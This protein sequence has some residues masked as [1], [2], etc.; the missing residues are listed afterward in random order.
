MRRDSWGLDLA[1]PVARGY[2]GATS[3]STVRSCE[4]LH[5]VGRRPGTRA[6]Q[7]RRAARRRSAL[8]CQKSCCTPSTNVTG[9][10]SE[11]CARSAAESLI[12]RSSQL[13]FSSAAT[14]AMTVRASSQRWQPGRDSSVTLGAGL[15]CTRAPRCRA[16]QMS[17]RS[18]AGSQDARS[19][20]C[21]NQARR[22]AQRPT[23]TARP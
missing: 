4:R 3:A 2:L 9:I 22:T 10:M 16:V 7:A 6:G 21:R 18:R 5:K 23:G 1:A 20:P 11:Y 8:T 19:Q 14:P 12:L 15:T 13:T 17:A